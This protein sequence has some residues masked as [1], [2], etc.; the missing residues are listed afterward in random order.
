MTQRR[1]WRKNLSLE[2]RALGGK[3][4]KGSMCAEMARGEGLRCST[5]GALTEKIC[6]GEVKVGGS[7]EG[8]IVFPRFFPRVLV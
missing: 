6:Q 5:E 7:R 8:I 1:N 3:P 4:Q 2:C